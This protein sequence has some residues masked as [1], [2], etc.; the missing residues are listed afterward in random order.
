VPLSQ[1]SKTNNVPDGGA[2]FPHVDSA[3]GGGDVGP[4][5][6]VPVGP[7]WGLSHKW[8]KIG[9]CADLIFG[10]VDEQKNWN[11]QKKT[12]RANAV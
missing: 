1:K 12:R 8:S 3:G 7:K 4:L 9:R 6:E 10:G 11:Q 2:T 5:G